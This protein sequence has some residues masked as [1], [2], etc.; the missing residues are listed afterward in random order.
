MTASKID[1]EIVSCL[2]Y[3]YSNGKIGMC[4]D[5]LLYSPNFVCP[6]GTFNVEGTNYCCSEPN[7]IIKD[8]YGYEK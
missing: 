8:G 2:N 5:V 6:E 1:E 3:I 7:M 4:K